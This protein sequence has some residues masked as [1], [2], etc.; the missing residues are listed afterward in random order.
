MY[1]QFF[2]LKMKPFELV[3]NPDF[4]FLSRGHKKALTYLKYGIGENIGFILLTGEVGS[5]KT[6]L[7]RDLIKGLNGNVTLSKVFNTKVTSDQ[8]ISLVNEDFGLEVT[9]KQ[10]VGMLRE[11]ND[12]L[13]DQHARRRQPILIIDEA[14]NL[15]PELLEEIRMLSNLETNMSKLLQIVLVGQPELRKTL[16]LP[17]MRQLRQRISISC[18]IQPLTRAE[19]EEYIYH[20]L[21]RAGSGIAVRFC[22]G[23]VD[24]IHEFSRGIPRLVNIMCDFLML[25]AYTN[26]TTE[27]TVDMAKEIVG[28]L[29]SENRFWQDEVPELPTARS[30]VEELSKRLPEIEE[31]IRNQGIR[32]EEAT[33]MPSEIS[34]SIRIMN[35]GIRQLRSQMWE[36]EIKV[37]TLT[38]DLIGIK[39][40][41]SSLKEAGRK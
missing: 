34:S 39:K 8:L 29:E 19:T 23:T 2:N 17:E 11:L 30:C 1:E 25:S 15:N 35:T 4:L 9:G 5:G 37:R 21:E 31:I 18:H 32:A 24:I 41:L 40:S 16:S 6:T 14:Q 27:I 3:P 22:E 26:K 10:K 13:I 7:I 38:A 12:F 33:E 20:R 36:M 28:E